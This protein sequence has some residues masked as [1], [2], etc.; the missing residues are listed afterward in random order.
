LYVVECCVAYFRFLANW[1]QFGKRQKNFVGNGFPSDTIFLRDHTY[2]A[3][4]FTLRSPIEIA[5][6]FT[7][8]L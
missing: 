4:L 5:Y 8:S 1:G 7:N 6:N 2:F 3:R